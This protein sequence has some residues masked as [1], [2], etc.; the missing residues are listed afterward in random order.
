VAGF[1]TVSESTR[2]VPAEPS[3]LVTVAAIVKETFDTATLAFEI[4]PEYQDAM[5]YQAGQFLTMA[6]PSELTG[7]VAR[8][9]SFCTAPSVDPRPAVTVKRTAEGYASNWLLDN[10]RVGDQVR[11]LAPGGIFS[12]KDWDAD[13]L[14]FA[15]GSGIT[16]LLSIL[17]EALTL[18]TGDVVLFYANSDE[19]SVIFGRTLSELAAAHPDRLTVVHWLESVQGL[20]LQEQ[21]RR[22]AAPYAD[23]EVFTCGPNGF[24]TTV[25]A[26][27]KELGLPRARRHRELFVSLGGAPFG[28]A[29]A[30]TGPQ[31]AP[32]GKVA[33]NVDV[34]IVVDGQVYEFDD[35][36]R[37]LPLVDFMLRKGLPAPFACRAAGCG[38]CVFTPVNGEVVEHVDNILTQSEL[39]AGMRLACQS[40]PVSDRLRVVFPDDPIGDRR[41]AREAA[42]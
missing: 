9:Y 36:P 25:D 32:A 42:E 17:K 3:Y 41:R 8:S 40:R 22:F 38:I 21:V 15:G 18:G 26:A 7:V 5:R 24:M 33:D 29:P 16:P 20:P 39:D 37:E 2:A 30:V 11:V 12:P 28:D 34:E 14:L 19:R 10:L 13:L 31:A 27:L 4:P 1:S 6:I 35:W 23:R